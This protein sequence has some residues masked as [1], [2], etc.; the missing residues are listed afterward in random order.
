MNTRSKS[1]KS[2]P[3][4]KKVSGHQSVKTTLL[5]TRSHTQSPAPVRVRNPPDGGD[6]WGSPVPK[7]GRGITGV[8]GGRGKTEGTKKEGGGEDKVV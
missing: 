4:R 2:F 6:H 7:V 3:E 5:V 1:G 8:E